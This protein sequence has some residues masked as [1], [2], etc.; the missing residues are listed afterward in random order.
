MSAIFLRGPLSNAF[1]RQENA[2]TVFEHSEKRSGTSGTL[3]NM[4]YVTVTYV[5]AMLRL[6][7]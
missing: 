6:M 1:I 7:M 4:Y 2:Q 5:T 3:Y